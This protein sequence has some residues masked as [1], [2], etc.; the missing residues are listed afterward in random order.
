MR[1]TSYVISVL[2][3]AAVNLLPAYAG[4]AQAPEVLAP[5]TH[6]R[7]ALLPDGRAASSKAAHALLAQMLSSLSAGSD[8]N[9]C[10]FC[11]EGAASCG[12]QRLDA[13]NN[14]RVSR[15]PGVD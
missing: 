12:D 8:T 14:R 5:K 4:G 9:S 6:I 15:L 3:L 1:Q 7:F 11:Y 10:P 13:S 2:L